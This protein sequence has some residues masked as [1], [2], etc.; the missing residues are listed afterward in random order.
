MKKEISMFKKLRNTCIVSAV[1]LA[2]I[3]PG[4][5]SATAISKDGIQIKTMFRLRLME[6]RLVSMT[7]S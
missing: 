4:Q 3:L 2:T 6:R 1:A 7:L 5:A